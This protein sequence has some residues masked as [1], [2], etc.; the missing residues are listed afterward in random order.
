MAE[1]FQVDPAALADALGRMDSFQ[2][3]SRALLDEIDA[4]VKNLHLGWEGEAATAHAWAHRQ[5]THGAAVMDQ[6]L[7]VLHRSGSGAHDNY[8]QAMA[9]NQKM[10]S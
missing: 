3:V 4:V 8:K 7:Q 1:A 5:W 2:K 10:W 6:A 9:T